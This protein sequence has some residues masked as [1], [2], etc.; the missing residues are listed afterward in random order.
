MA[1]HT[2]EIRKLAKLTGPILV[3]QLTQMLMSVVDTVMAG[4]KDAVDLAAVSV[5]GSIFVPV[6]LLMFGIALALAPIVSHFDGSKKYRR[7]AN[8]LQ[9]GLYACAIF[10]VL[11][12]V[13]LQFSPYILDWMEVEDRFRQ[14]TLDYVNY[15]AWGVPGFVIYVILRNFCEGL[16]NTMPS[17]VIG[18]IGLL[19]NI[20]A[21]YIFIYGHFGAPEL[22]GAGCGLASALVFWGMAISMAI[23]VFT[24]RR[25]K[26]LH[27]LRRWY[28]PK[29][30]DVAYIIKIGFP[31]AM[32]LFFEVSLFAAVALLIAPLGPTV[33]SAHQIALNISSLVYMVPLSISMAVTLRV[34]FALGAGEPKNAMLSFK[35]AMVFGMVFA[36]VNG[37]IMYLGGAWLASL[38]TPDTAIINLAATLMGLAAIFTMS[39]TF[40]AVAMGTLRGYKD[41][42]WP[43]IMAFISYWP[44][45]LT[46]GYILGRTDWWVPRMGAAGFW[47]GFISGLTVAAV[48][49]TIRLRF[50]SKHYERKQFEQTVNNAT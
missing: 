15:I 48:M 3:A 49:L 41:T 34:G 1:K 18:F 19:I 36:A 39:D 26:K 16:S 43:M 6:T 8:M 28:P 24:S 12:L 27:L 30:D 33:V 20:P 46:V 17:L 23:Y 10:G 11:A 44:F 31:I 9:Q 29:F 22:G 25:Y 40:Q 45:G 21:N 37:I 5:G 2:H 13:V 35:I 47:I 7:M 32:S 4:R 38:Y 50:V 14:V 42:K